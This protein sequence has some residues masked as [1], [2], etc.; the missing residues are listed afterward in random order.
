[1]LARELGTEPSAETERLKAAI[2]AGE[3]QTMSMPVSSG[4]AGSSAHV[5]EEPSIAV[6][7]FTSLSDDTE[8]AYFADGISA[9][10]ISELGRFGELMVTAASS[11]FSFKGQSLAIGDIAARLGV[12]YLVEGSVRRAG[13]RVR[14]TV[15]LIEGASGNRIWGERYDR[16][17]S[18]IFAV[19][20]EIASSVATAVAGGIQRLG[21]NRAQR[22]P[23]ENLGAYEC[24]LRAR[25]LQNHYDGFAKGLPFVKK[26][27]EL[28]PGF[29]LAQAALSTLQLVEYLYTSD[30]RDHEP[31][32]ASA[33]K[34]LLLDPQEAACQSALG[35]ALIFTG[36][37]DESQAHF[38]KALELNRNYVW[39][40]MLRGE[41]SMYQGKHDAA[42]ADID[43]CFRRDPYPADWFWDVRG[44]ALVSAGRDEEALATYARMAAVPPWGHWYMAISYL[45]LGDAAKARDA[46]AVYMAF[47]PQGSTTKALSTDPYIPEIKESLRAALIAAGMPA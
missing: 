40:R 16:D 42:M 3:D 25:V 36:R 10:I 7:P 44:M 35:H 41:C 28:D 39:A 8:Q 11:S 13:D 26:A 12:K 22:L 6:L 5:H 15:Q 29:A 14:I 46:I 45:R 9:D 23:T 2:A 1:M 43:E 47:D 31:A 4:T 33:R 17:L 30:P 27:I 34:A 32:L 38:N 20:D 21:A 18:D 24:Y 37:L 19:Q